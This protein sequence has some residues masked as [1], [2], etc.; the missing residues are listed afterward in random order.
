MHI[1]KK[2]ARYLLFFNFIFIYINNNA[3]SIKLN[4]IFNIHKYH[5][6]HPYTYHFPDKQSMASLP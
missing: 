3:F 6:S 5:I 4:S 1:F 2:S